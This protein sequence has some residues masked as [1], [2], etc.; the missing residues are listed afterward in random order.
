LQRFVRIKEVVKLTGLSRTSIWRLS[1]RGGFPRA[2]ML[3][4]ADGKIRAWVLAEIVAWMRSR[5]AERDAGAAAA[6]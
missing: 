6:G 5:V 2:V 4:G 1:R 3:S